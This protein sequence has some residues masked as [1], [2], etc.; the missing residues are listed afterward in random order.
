MRYDMRASWFADR[1]ITMAVKMGWNVT[2]RL[3]RL[4][5]AFMKLPTARAR[6]AGTWHVCLAASNCDVTIIWNTGEV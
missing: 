4:I 3:F 5:E 1:V 6:T 2:L